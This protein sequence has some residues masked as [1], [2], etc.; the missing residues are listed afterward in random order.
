[1]ALLTTLGKGQGYLKMGFLGFQASGKTYTACSMAI[2]LRKY[3]K[4][5][6]PVA[7]FDTEGGSEYIA[8]RVKKETG[9]DLLGVKSQSFQDLVDMADECVQAGVSVLIADS[10]THVWRELCDSYLEHVNQQRSKK[11]MPNRSKLEFQDWTPIK[12]KWAEWTTFYLNSPLHI[13]ICG[14]AGYEYDMDKN[15]ETGQKELVKTG[16]KMKTETEFGFEPSLL[17]EM[18]RIQVPQ[19]D[20]GFKMVHHAKVIKDR[21]SVMDGMEIDNPTFDFFLPHVAKLTPG[22]VATIN[23]SAKTP[24]HIDELGMDDFERRKLRQKKAWEEVENGLMIIYPGAVGKDKQA[25]LTILSTLTGSTSE[26]KIQ[27]LPPEQLENM[28]LAIRDFGKDVLAGVVIEN[29]SAYIKR[30]YDK[31]VEGDAAPAE[32]TAGKEGPAQEDTAG[33]AADP[34]S[35][36]AP[37]ST[38]DTTTAINEAMTLEAISQ[39][40]NEAV[41]SMSKQE[42]AVVQKAAEERKRQLKRR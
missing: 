17:I 24:M 22:V 26:T 29:A 28:A 37:S 2:G 11:N 20:G 36:P 14:R 25:K 1:M 13:I 27:Q 35:S 9:K 16:L 19:R 39:I 12:R 10:M 5:M 18:E 3:A 4:L 23:T 40:L 32:G 38:F 33:L 15:E 21:F 31:Y 8:E 41:R 42:L 7:M 6:G 30:I 34:T